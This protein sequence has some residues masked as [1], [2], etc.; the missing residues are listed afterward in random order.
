[1]TTI[2]GHYPV[3]FTTPTTFPGVNHYT[4]LYWYHST[5]TT[6]HA[7]MYNERHK[8]YLLCWM[9]DVKASR[10]SD[11]KCTERFHIRIT[12]WKETL[13]LRNTHTWSHTHTH[14]HTHTPAAAAAA[15]YDSEYTHAHTHEQWEYKTF[16]FSL[17]TKIQTCRYTDTLDTGRR[18]KKCTDKWCRQD[19]HT[20]T[21]THTHTQ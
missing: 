5:G 11:R 18:L 20:H 9:R 2:H 3:Y 17:N 1:M 21:H 10:Q 12:I 6:K 13:M 4:S 7:L 8:T 19:T 16:L 14:T 15:D